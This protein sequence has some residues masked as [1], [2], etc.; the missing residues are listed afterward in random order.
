MDQEVAPKY[1]P[2]DVIQKF[3]ELGSKFF[4]KKDDKIKFMSPLLKL[5]LYQV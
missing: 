2:A 1:C 3:G 4:D 5:P